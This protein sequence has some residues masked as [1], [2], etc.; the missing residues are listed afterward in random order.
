MSVVFL[1][2]FGVAGG[3]I[4]SLFVVDLAIAML[5]RTVP[6]MNVLILGFQVKSLML[7]LTLP[8]TL[9]LSATLLARMTRLTLEAIPGLL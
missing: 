6:Q 5:S 1:T 9:G 7:F 3:A 2:S 8:I 4:L